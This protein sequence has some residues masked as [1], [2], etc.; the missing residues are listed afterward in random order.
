[1]PIFRGPLWG[2][3]CTRSHCWLSHTRCTCWHRG[4]AYGQQM[5][6]KCTPDHT[7]KNHRTHTSVRLQHVHGPYA[8]H[9]SIRVHVKKNCRTDTWT[10]APS[11]SH[12]AQDVPIIA[13]NQSRQKPQF[14]WHFQQFC[15]GKN[16]YYMAFD[17]RRDF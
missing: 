17:E 8:C 9:T 4:R 12:S 15:F 2:C 1:M 5:G 14:S 3:R 10:W 16:K 7:K 13:K 6:C 11:L